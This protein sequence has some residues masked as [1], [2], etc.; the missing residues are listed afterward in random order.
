MNEFTVHSNE[1]SLL[2]EMPLS[3]SANSGEV[4]RDV[5]IPKEFRIFYEMKTLMNFALPTVVVQFSTLFLYPQC[6]SAIGRQLDTE[7]L[8]AF[9]L[10][11]LSGNMTC[12]SIIIGTLTACETLQPRA[13]GLGQYRE[14]GL[15]AIRGLFMCI[16][17]L[18]VPI[19]VLL[20]RAESIFD[21]L[22]QDPDAS[23]LA[24]EWIKVYVWSVPPL[25]LFRVIQRYLACQNIV[26]PCVFGAVIGCFFVHP[27]V[28]QWSIAKYGFLGSSWAIVITQT[29]Q[30]TLCLGFIV[31][32]GFYDK[33]TWPGVNSSV[34]AEA[35]DVRELFTFARLSIAGIL[36][37]SE[38]WFWECICFMAGKFGL[39]ELCVHTVSYQIIPIAFMIPLGIS[40][41][42]SVRLGM[43]LPVNV[44]GAKR[45]AA[46]TMLITIA[47]GIALSTLIFKNQIW[48]V[49]MFTTDERV[50]DGC[51]KIWLN[52]CM[53]NVL[54]WVFCISRGILS[55]LGKQWWTAAT[56]FLLLWCGTVPA[57]LHY[58]VYN[59]GGFYLMWNMLPSA[60]LVLNVGLACCYLTAD[61]VQ[62]G[63]DI[64]LNTKCRNQELSNTKFNNS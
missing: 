21:N 25:L 43:L 5:E 17:S 47:I 24:T 35:M 4:T 20:T 40:I 3:P 8:A 44:S 63:A 53:F 18:L 30:C 26:I 50:F 56:M 29:V 54:L 39:V 14:V 42:L 9:S 13:F 34:F 41:G 60:Y 36:S 37:L 49:S 48:I 59:D 33:R 31:L 15:L 52:L 10:G 16:L 6:A 1:S 23:I 58:C 22:G 57:I 11:S 55:A 51:E 32:T 61:W 64:R 7:S 38:W 19:T 2:L 12:I 46:Y 27:F 62:I 28:L 45:L